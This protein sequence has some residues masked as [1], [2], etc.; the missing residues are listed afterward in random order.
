MA[1]TADQLSALNE[2]ISQGAMRVK[3]ADKEVEYRT[4]N[5]MLRLRDLMEKELG[6]KKTGI[7]FSF[8]QFSTGLNNGNCEK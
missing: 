4:L 5:E 2:A 8:A 3:Y 1:F 6:T 7:H